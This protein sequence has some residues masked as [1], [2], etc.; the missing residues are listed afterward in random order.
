MADTVK[1]YEGGV[2]PQGFSGTFPHQVGAQEQVKP[3]AG[4]SEVKTNPQDDS[5]A[6]SSGSSNLGVIAEAGYRAAGEERVDGGMKIRTHDTLKS[7]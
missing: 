2:P 1:V 6:T 4:P 7:V 3:D 5:G